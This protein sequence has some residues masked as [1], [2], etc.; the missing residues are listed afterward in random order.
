MMILIFSMST[1]TPSLH[2]MWPKRISIGVE[3]MQFLILRDNWICIHHSI[4]NM[5]H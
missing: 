1:F 3:N 5:S 2:T 4:I